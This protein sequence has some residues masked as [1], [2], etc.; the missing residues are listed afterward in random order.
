VHLQSLGS[1]FVTDSFFVNDTWSVGSR[2]SFNLGLRYDRND[3]VDSAGHPVSEDSNLS[4]R[5][6]AT[7]D[8]SGDGRIR[9]NASYSKYVGKVGEFGGGAA[10][11]GNYSEFIYEYRGP[12]VGG[13][14]SGLGSY[15][16]L[17]QVFSWFLAQGGTDALD[18][19]I[20]SSVPHVSNRVVPLD[21]ANAE[22][23][24]IGAGVQLGGNG[25]VRLDLIDR[26]WRDFVAG[27]N[28]PGDTVENPYWPGVLIDVNTQ[29]NDQDLTRTYQAV[30]IQGTYR[31][32]Q[33]WS[34]GG[35]YTWSK[36]RGNWDDFDPNFVSNYP[37]LY[38]EYKN[39]ARFS[40]VGRT[41]L[42]QP[43][44]ARLWLGWDRPVGRLGRLNVSLLESVD[45][46]R[47]Y[48]A[49]SLVPAGQ[50]IR[51]TPYV[52]NPGYATPPSRVNY[53]FSDRGEYRWDTATSTDVA[54]NYE[55]PIRRARV[56]IQAELLNV[57]D[58]QAQINGST[59]VGFIAPFDPFTETP[60]ECPQGST[61]CAG[62][63]WQKPAMFGK[64]RS[65][66]DYQRPRTYRFS[67]GF[68]F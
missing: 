49:A 8:L 36:T 13:P 1:D 68:R 21:S 63:H 55:I 54:L 31:F 41:A 23:W 61:D 62:A 65:A 29:S 3:S 20:S 18:L 15:D 67:A 50:G 28:A 46:G 52:T 64:A 66:S 45:S 60:R 53:Y 42:D 38:A 27:S 22:E 56:F 19:L 58:E 9:L 33:A 30:V 43:H 25:Y 35:N 2:W 48:S 57:F 14:G 47:A 24:T 5:L 51:I 17:E 39:F 34:L 10:G 12:T 44:K 37:H 59:R 40:P 6:G 11:G 7:F 32:G 26:E 16:V 4:P